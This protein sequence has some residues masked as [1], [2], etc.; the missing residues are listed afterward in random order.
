MFEG[1]NNEGRKWECLRNTTRPFSS[2]ACP[3][4][5]II[6]NRAIDSS[7]KDYSSLYLVQEKYVYCRSPAKPRWQGGSVTDVAM[8]VYLYAC[9]RSYQ[10]IIL[11]VLSR[12]MIA[13]VGIRFK[14]TI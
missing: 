13:P 3:R 7:K 12:R 5:Q 6:Q 11:C 8:H 2:T 4:Y 14:H 10:I 1:R 9:I